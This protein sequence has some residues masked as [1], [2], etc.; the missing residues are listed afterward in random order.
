MRNLIFRLDLDNGKYAGTGHFKRIESLYFFLKK[1]FLDLEFYFL[2]KN[3]INSKNILKSL[4][5]KNHIIFNKSY[6]K[7][8]NFINQ[9]DI[10]IIDT[11]F[12][13]DTNFKNFLEKK[14]MKKIIMIDDLNSPNL[15]NCTI[16]NGI[17]SFKKKIKTR[18]SIK[19]YSGKKYLFLDKAYSGKIIKKKVI[20]LQFW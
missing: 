2:Y 7:K 15:K 16:L 9:D 6:R 4:S 18:R 19:L 1:E 12:G 13:I 5:N 17:I 3:L 20:S 11:P 8:L 14:E 10:C